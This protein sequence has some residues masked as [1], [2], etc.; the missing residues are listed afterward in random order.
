MKALHAVAFILVIVG[1]LNW[2]LVGLFDLNVVTFLGAVVAKIVYV[3]VGLSA[4][5]LV[6][7]HK[8]S[9]ADCKAPSVNPSM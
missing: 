4:V 3:L 7:T 8:K 6:V 5:Y 1:S 2:L 9:C